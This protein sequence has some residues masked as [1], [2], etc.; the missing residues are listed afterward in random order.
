MSIIAH[1]ILIYF[2][3]QRF[4]ELMTEYAHS[5]PEHDQYAIKY[6]INAC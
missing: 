5:Y 6:L 3:H 4:I 1:L 2:D